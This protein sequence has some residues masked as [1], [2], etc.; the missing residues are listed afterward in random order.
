MGG[1]DQACTQ[2]RGQRTVSHPGIGE[3]RQTLPGQCSYLE[4][5][6]NVHNLLPL[7]GKKR[8]NAKTFSSTHFQHIILCSM[9]QCI[10]WCMKTK[11][12]IK[13]VYFVTQLLAMWVQIFGGWN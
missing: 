7:D 12:Y 11:F 2:L 9:L 5:D 3:S 1:H 13:T 4:W 8:A 6:Q 10:G